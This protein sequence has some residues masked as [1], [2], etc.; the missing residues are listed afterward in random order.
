MA[1]ALDIALDV[2]KPAAAKKGP[3]TVEEDSAVRQAR[4]EGI[5]KWSD[6][7]KRVP[8]RMG[9]QCR[10]RWCNH[11]DPS[12]RKGPWTDE[13][14]HVLVEK[15]KVMGNKW[16]QIAK[17]IPGRPE[18]A[19]KNRW[20][21]FVHKKMTKM[22]REGASA[23]QIASTL[24]QENGR[25]SMQSLTAGVGSV[26]AQRVGGWGGMVGG[27][28][29]FPEPQ[30]LGKSNTFQKP[31]L[32]T[33]PELDQTLDALAALAPPTPGD[34]PWPRSARTPASAR[35]ANAIWGEP[36]ASSS[37]S[38][39]G[40]GG[41]AGGAS[42]RAG[43]SSSGM[44]STRASGAR[45]ARGGKP[46]LGSTTAAGGGASGFSF[47]DNLS[48]FSPRLFER[49]TPSAAASSAA[50]EPAG[51][52]PNR[53]AAAPDGSKPAL[54][55]KPPPP[56]GNPKIRAA[57]ANAKAA[58]KAKAE[59][60]AEEEEEEKQKAAK[61]KGGKSPGLSKPLANVSLGKTPRAGGSK[62]RARKAAAAAVDG[63]DDD[64][65]VME[66]STRSKR[67]RR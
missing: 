4:L 53:R 57:R 49:A 52:P 14:D 13:E 27:G 21:S 8:G 33:G 30:P 2:V 41:G 56:K 29:H 24:V 9:K 23:E 3:W 50:A 11:L 31:T 43:G 15:Q 20:N 5:E 40:G 61:K 32:I 34:W 10:E 58:A 39:G 45:S 63:G 65:E 51:P 26:A 25:G 64:E 35:A 16:A 22:A 54:R 1:D 38:S 37:S 47:D 60:A 36:G 28:G 62:P 46:P 7:A 6:I 19:I 55:R 67:G 44:G 12:I 42:S 66:A 17:L 18:N 59:A 48:L